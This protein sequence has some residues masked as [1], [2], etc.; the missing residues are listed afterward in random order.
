[1][2]AT[3]ENIRAAILAAPSKMTMQL[4]RELGV[5]EAEVIRAMPDGQSLELDLERWEE[6]VRSFEPLG[7]VH[8]I[9]SNGAVTLEAFGQFG[10]FSTTGPFFNVQTSDIDM[11]IRFRELGACFAVEKPGH[12]DGV[13]T[14]SVQFYDKLGNSAFKVFLSFGAK[15]PTEER[16]TY[17]ASLRE[18]LAKK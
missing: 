6:I 11:H 16:K 8:V 14:L 12:M 9:A 17:F 18:R 2:S 3:P 5:P 15:P 4:A 10:N 7:K 13:T 1:M